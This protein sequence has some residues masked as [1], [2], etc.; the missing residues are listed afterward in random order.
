VIL[1]LNGQTH[2]HQKVHTSRDKR[3]ALSEDRPL[4]FSRHMDGLDRH[5]RHQAN[6]VEGEHTLFGFL[7]TDCQCGRE[8]GARK[9]MPVIL[10]TRKELELWM[11][12]PADEALSLQRPA[13]D[14]TLRIVARG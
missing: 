12:A 2:V 14:E 6:P 10:T 7:K 4:A 11:S 3:I 5:A 9:G 1:P 13:L 8:A